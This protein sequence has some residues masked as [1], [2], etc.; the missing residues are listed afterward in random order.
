MCVP[1]AVLLES[2][3]L[4]LSLT[5]CAEGSGSETELCSV[6]EPLL[7]CRRHS[8]RGSRGASLAPIGAESLCGRCVP[9]GQEVELAQVLS[10]QERVQA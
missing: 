6:S 8:P 4:S 9:R 2:S 10:P 3:M 1:A 7:C 5:Q